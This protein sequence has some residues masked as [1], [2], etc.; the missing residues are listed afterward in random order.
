MRREQRSSGQVRRI[1]NDEKTQLLSHMI[2]EKLETMDPQQPVDVS[3]MVEQIR[4]WPTFAGAKDDEVRAVAIR[5]CNWLRRVCPHDVA[6]D[7][8]G[9]RD[10]A[11]QRYETEGLVGKVQ[12]E[13]GPD[14]PKRGSEQH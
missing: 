3:S 11:Q 5:H 1:V 14:Q 9:E 10:Q 13:R 7:H 8:A 12:G 4:P 6:H 2:R